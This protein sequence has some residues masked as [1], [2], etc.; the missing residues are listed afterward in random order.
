MKLKRQGGKQWMDP[1]AICR[2]Y[3]SMTEYVE[4]HPSMDITPTNTFTRPA[5]Y[6]NIVGTTKSITIKK[7][8]PTT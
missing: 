3:T 8:I 7:L 6:G 4:Y 5:T 2:H 1:S